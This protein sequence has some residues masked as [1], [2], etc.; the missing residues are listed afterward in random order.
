[1]KI[2]PV[3]AQL[4]H[5]D[6]LET[7]SRL[8]NFANPPT[9]GRGRKRPSLAGHLTGRGSTS[10]KLWSQ[11]GGKKA[12]VST[13]CDVWVGCESRNVYLSGRFQETSVAASQTPTHLLVIHGPPLINKPHDKTNTCTN[14]KII[15]LH[16]AYRNSD[17]FRF[18]LIF[19]TYLK[20]I[21]KAYIKAWMG[22]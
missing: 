16:T 22:Y 12:Q 15:F 3:G 18:I 19:F 11:T 4:F 9:K 5:S 7:N 13:K 8:S 2:R 1:M 20:N 17:M 10:A 14:V 21:N 6:G